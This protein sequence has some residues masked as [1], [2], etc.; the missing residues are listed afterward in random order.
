MGNF[1]QY[2]PVFGFKFAFDGIHN[3]PSSQLYAALIMLNPPGGIYGNPPDPKQ[4]SLRSQADWEGPLTSPRFIDG[5]EQFT[6]IDLQINSH[7]IVDIKSINLSK[8]TPQVTTVGWTIVPL[9]N[10]S[11]Y[12]L[13]GLYQIPV[14][15]GQVNQQILESIKNSELT[16]WEVVLQNIQAKK[17]TIKWL[18]TTSILARL[19]DSQREVRLFI[20]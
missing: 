10:K 16:P 11:H 5:Y 9:L 19:L 13:S 3:P 4:V 14:I 17:P 6:G 20:T 12:L 18:G 15:A 8:K 2:S 7:I 1:A